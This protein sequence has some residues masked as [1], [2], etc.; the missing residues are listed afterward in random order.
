MNSFPKLIDFNIN[1]IQDLNTEEMLLDLI[2]FNCDK[3]LSSLFIFCLSQKI[4]YLS[5]PLHFWISVTVYSLYL[6]IPLLLV[7]PYHPKQK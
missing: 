1:S 4:I 3:E 2:Q 6:Q 5:D 7:I